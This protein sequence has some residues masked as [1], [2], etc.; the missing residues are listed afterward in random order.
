MS[1]QPGNP[2]PLDPFGTWRSL[3]NTYL[4]T[5]SKAMI[6]MVNTEEYAE[7]MG[8]MLD[9]Y[10]TTSVPFRQM[11]KKLMVEVLDQLNMPTRGDVTSLA[12]RLTNIEM[13]LDDLDARLDT[14]ERS[15][16]QIT[17]AASA[18]DRRS[19]KEEH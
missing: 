2:N 5:M 1:N 10:L 9:M 6:E 3:Q 19:E 18:L 12:Q 16:S 8:R 7:A 4:E 17:Q 14:F 11:Q 15:A 13:R